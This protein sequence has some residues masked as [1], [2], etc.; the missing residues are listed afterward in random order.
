MFF[1]IIFLSN[2]QPW[3]KRKN[4][5]NNIV[6]DVFVVV[7]VSPP[8]LLVAWFF[9]LFSFRILS[10]FRRYQNTPQTVNGRIEEFSTAFVQI[11]F[12]IKTTHIKL[13]TW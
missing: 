5:K 8:I 7:F 4:N 13:L 6:Q 10:K 1:I 11:A 2:I 9:S 12:S 3:E